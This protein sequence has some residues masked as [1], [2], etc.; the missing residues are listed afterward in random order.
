MFRFDYVGMHGPEPGAFARCAVLVAAIVAL[1]AAPARAQDASLTT[2]RFEVMTSKQAEEAGVAAS[3][4]VRTARANV[5]AQD[6]ALAEARGTNGVAAFAGYA[7]V[8]QSSGMSSTIQQHIE[9]AGLQLTL[10]DL[11]SNSPLVIAA[12]ASAAQART[13]E[14][15]AERTERLKVATLYFAAVRARALTFAKNDAVRSAEDFEGEV[16]AKFGAGK[17]PRLDLLRS[18][19]AL[20]R[21]RADQADTVGADLNAVDALAREVGRP[22]AD[23]RAMADERSHDYAILS[24]S[25][26]VDQALANRPEVGSAAANVAAARAG[27]DAA[28]RAAIPPIQV[29]AGYAA[30][31]DAG[32]PINGPSIVAQMTVPLSGIGAAKVR[33]AQAALEAALAKK[34]SV[35][36][37]LAIEVGSAVRTAAATVIA[38]TQT[39]LALTISKSELDLVLDEY[40]RTNARGLD[41]AAVRDLY[42]QAVADDITAQYDELQA[43]AILNIEESP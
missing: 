5:A 20:A 23:F 28:R 12:V 33:A 42:T 7:D 43:H 38:R 8:P 39:A 32:Q 13:D 19:I 11:L 21:A 30:G 37:G 14:L 31:V 41:V 25:V 24:D 17:V 40:R 15:V 36:R 16:S 27:V 35:E 26:A 9:A 3:P 10:G 29:Q 18:E 6:A 22:A 4:D 2:L 34:E 1:A